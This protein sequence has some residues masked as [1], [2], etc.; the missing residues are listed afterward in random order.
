LPAASARALPLRAP[1]AR[2]NDNP[3]VR[4]LFEDEE[5][6]YLDLMLR[7]ERLATQPAQPDLLDLPVLRMPP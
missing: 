3:F 1:N 7:C 4:E 5:R 6:I 2:R